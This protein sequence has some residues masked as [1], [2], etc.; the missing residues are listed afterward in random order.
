MN[1]NMLLQCLAMSFINMCIF[2]Q[3][4][5]HFNIYLPFTNEDKSIFCTFVHIFDSISNCE[6]CTY[7]TY[8]FL[9]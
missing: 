5:G 2:S 4:A 9:N 1:A 8:I 7:I 3:Y 6:I